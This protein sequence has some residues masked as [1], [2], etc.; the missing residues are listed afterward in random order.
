[1]ESD[2]EKVYFVVPDIE[3][4]ETSPL[5][6]T[7]NADLLAGQTWQVTDDGFINFSAYRVAYNYNLDDFVVQPPVSFVLKI[8]IIC[9][10]SQ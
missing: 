8:Y 5:I 2:N 4:L 7:S 1:L 10:Y 9:T 6:L 3:A